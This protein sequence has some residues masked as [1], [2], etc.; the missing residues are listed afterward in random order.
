M[1]NIMKDYNQIHWE[2]REY[3]CTICFDDFAYLFIVYL[4]AHKYDIK[5]IKNIIHIWENI[6]RC[7]K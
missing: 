6:L 3:S 2:S 5:N 7:R 1:Y 4:V